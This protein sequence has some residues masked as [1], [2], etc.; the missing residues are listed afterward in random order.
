MKAKVLLCVCVLA[1]LAASG[2]FAET[3]AILLLDRTGSMLELRAS[4]NT[5]C[6]DALAQAKLDVKT[7][8]RLNPE[9]DGSRIQIWTFSEVGVFPRTGYVGQSDALAALNRSDLAPDGCVGRTPL[10]DALCTTTDQ[11]QGQHLE[12]PVM[13]REIRLSTDGGEN[14]SRGVCLA[15]DS[16]TEGYDCDDYEVPSW[17]YNVCDN[18]RTK[19]E[20]VVWKIRYWEASTKSGTDPET[21]APLN[22][23]AASDQ[24]FFDFLAQDSGGTHTS[25]ANCADTDGDVIC[26]VDDNCYLDVNPDQYDC[27]LDGDGDICDGDVP[28]PDS[29]GVDGEEFDVGCDNCWNEAN[30]N[31]A[32]R[33]G[34]GAGDPCDVCPEDPLDDDDT[35]GYCVGAGFQAQI[36]PSIIGDRDNCP[37]DHNPGQGDADNDEIGD[38]CDNCPDHLNWSQADRD[39]DGVGDDCDNCPDDHN[40]LQVDADTDGVGDPCDNCGN[41]F[42][43]SQSDCDGNGQ[44][45]ACQPGTADADAD[46][47]A[48]GCD[49]CPLD[50][51]PYQINRDAD[52]TGDPCDVCPEDPTDDG[53]ADGLCAGTGFQSHLDPSI[54]GDRDNCPTVWNLDQ[55]DL[56]SD[57][58]G[59]LCDNC[60]F[61]R[62]PAQT[63]SNSDG[64]GDLCDE[65]DGLIYFTAV[66][67]ED[68]TISPVSTYFEWQHEQGTYVDGYHFYRGGLEVLRSSGTYS[69]HPDIHGPNAAKV[70]DL[71][72]PFYLEEL[73]EPGPGECVF[74]LVGGRL[75][76]CHE[77]DLGK[78]SAGNIRPHGHRCMGS[79]TQ[80]AID[81]DMDGMHLISLPREI[82]K[83]PITD[84]RELIQAM[85]MAALEP[86][87]AARF[88]P[89]TDDWMMWTEDDPL[90]PFP[91]DPFAG[92]AYLVLAADG[93]GQL[94]I[95]G[96]DCTSEVVLDGP[97][98]NGSATGM[99]AISL[100]FSANTT[101]NDAEDLMAD[102]NQGSS[103]VVSVSRFLTVS[104]SLQTYDGLA[105]ANFLIVPGEGYHVRLNT[106]TSYTPYTEWLPLL[107]LAGT[108]L[109]LA[110]AI[111]GTDYLAIILGCICVGMLGMLF[112]RL[113]RGSKERS[114]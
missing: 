48:D 96:F 57:G 11:I 104:E 28:D 86:V 107:A 64:Q 84:A 114:L 37:L 6:A 43:P 54:I 76:E 41:A 95:D 31:Q 82:V 88:N 30:P 3:Q 26:D 20:E 63:D 10:A 36:D 73:F 39:T 87:F 25:M 8:F 110:A 65:S 4:G 12:V 38:L 34:D 94:L 103:V 97:G 71:T 70:C 27:D 108:K 35:D 79:A 111:F 51:N 69:Q 1:C 56:D 18:L 58:V 93:S 55:A 47:V 109:I 60:Q 50:W 113:S 29:D 7:F 15:Q 112:R 59:D 74:Y 32:D 72:D 2:A 89:V 21:G 22:R 80:M 91:I 78:D 14:G 100:P 17:Q 102:I 13:S 85:E 45:D 66:I 24:I 49:N 99:Q 106:T 5:R 42:N 44:G 81:F 68:P 46:G 105:G 92:W 98:S 23:I 67:N 61:D 52:G 62:N 101:L 75:D 19:D 77:H 16:S 9:A 40:P 53:D 83:P 33:D 90:P